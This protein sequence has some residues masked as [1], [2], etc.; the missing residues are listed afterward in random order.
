MT[1]AGRTLVLANLFFVILWI[2]VYTGNLNQV[3]E[4]RKR[5]KKSF[6]NKGRVSDELPE[7]QRISVYTGNLNQVS[8]KRKKKEK[9]TVYIGNRNKARDEQVIIRRKKKRRKMKLCTGMLTR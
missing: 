4:N 8:E 3:S 1:H 5:K 9:K 2:S 7:I 6:T